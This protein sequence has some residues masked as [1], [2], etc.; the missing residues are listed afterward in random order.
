MGK[1]KEDILPL[2]KKLLKLTITTIGLG[3]IFRNYYSTLHL[4]WFQNIE[5]YYTTLIKKAEEEGQPKLVKY[6]KGKR[7]RRLNLLYKSTKNSEAALSK[8][9]DTFKNYTPGTDDMI[10]SFVDSLSDSVYDIV[11]VDDENVTIKEPNDGK[12]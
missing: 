9:I 3:E 6:L 7:K 8:G 5:K 1:R 12:N 2:D 10:E 4:E 11:E